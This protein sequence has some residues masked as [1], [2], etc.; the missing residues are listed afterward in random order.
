MWNKYDNGKSIGT[1]G[2]EGTILDDVEHDEG[3]RITLEKSDSY[4]AITYGLYGNM[5]D[6]LFGDEDKMRRTFESLQVE[7][8]Y[9]KYIPCNRG[10][11]PICNYCNELGDR[12]TLA[13]DE[14]HNIPEHL[15]HNYECFSINHFISDMFPR[16]KRKFKN[17]ELGICFYSDS[18]KAFSEIYKPLLVKALDK[19]DNKSLEKF[20]NI[21]EDIS[22]SNNEYIYKFLNETF[23]KYL[24]SLDNNQFDII[25]PYLLD[26]TIKRMEKLYI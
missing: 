9:Y 12:R 22:Y 17:H 3:M 13:S 4:F 10:F 19:N 24:L 2:S 21:I 8:E 18:F 15:K 25:K 23:I 26:N 6:T 1:K 20:G 5:V 14:D 16:L 11:S 7:L